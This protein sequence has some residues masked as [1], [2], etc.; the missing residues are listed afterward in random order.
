MCDILK[1]Y[2]DSFLKNM[3][4]YYYYDNPKTPEP[5]ITQQPT[6]HKTQIK[7]HLQAPKTQQPTEHPQAPKTPEAPSYVIHLTKFHKTLT[8]DHVDRLNAKYGEGLALVTNS[9]LYLSNIHQIDIQND[10]GK[11]LEY[12]LEDKNT[13]YITDDAKTL[14][15]CSK[16]DFVIKK[17]TDLEMI[18]T[19]LCDVP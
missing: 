9:L 14:R 1:T 12:Y 11:E 3:K 18:I 16:N 5:P 17:P 4:S 15:V 19:I 7:E 13:K 10:E 6:E 8:Q 2:L